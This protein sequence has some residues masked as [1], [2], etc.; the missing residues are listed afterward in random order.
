MVVWEVG[1]V[2][3]FGIWFLC[4]GVSHPLSITLRSSLRIKGI[5][6]HGIESKVSLYA[7]DLLL[8]L[9]DPLETIPVAESTLKEFGSFSGY[10]LN[11]QK[12]ECFP[13]SRDAHNL[14]QAAIPFRLSPAGFR[15]LG[16]NI[17]HNI[18]SI[19]RANFPPLIAE[20]NADFQRWN[21][22]PLSLA[23]RVQCVK[24]S[25]LPIFLY[26]FQCLPVFLPKSFFKDIDKAVTNFIWSGKVPRIRKP[27]LQKSKIDSGLALPN[28][29][30]YYLAANVQ[31]ICFWLHSPEIDW[32]RL[33]SLLCSSTSL[34][35]MI[36][37]T[38]PLSQE[39]YSVN[40][41]VL[42]TLK[43]W[44]QLS[45]L[46]KSQ[47]ASSLIPIRSNHLFPPSLT[48]STFLQWANLGINNFRDLYENKIFS[49]FEKLSDKFKLPPTNF[50]RYLQPVVN[51]SCFPEINSV[52]SCCK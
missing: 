22:L 49:S 43:I 32:C 25:I 10:K 39:Q 27:I 14:T 29:F 47:N 35:A 26:L 2:W 33:E 19:V 12:S 18:S 13:V 52:I 8:Y 44:S 42:S 5:L 50:F 48:D 21:S 30:Y 38:L 24:M 11:F 31:K 23:G 20:M 6:R 36:F 51:V 1:G 15:Y 3:V 40:P 4:C 16:V 9:R 45:G 41:V 28:F 37:S 46:A 7:D 17:T 34:L